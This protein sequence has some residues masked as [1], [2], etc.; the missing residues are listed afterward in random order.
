MPIPSASL[1]S[2]LL[3]RRDWHYRACLAITGSYRQ[4]DV[5][6]LE[7]FRAVVDHRSVTLAAA[8]LRVMQP[9]VSTQIACLDRG[10][11]R[12]KPTPEGMLFYAEADKML[13]GMNCLSEAVRQIR[14]AQAGFIIANH[15]SA[16][17]Y[18]EIIAS[19]VRD[20]EPSVLPQ[21]FLLMLVDK[22]GPL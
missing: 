3:A 9:P 2:P 22:L 14:T 11:G 4:M 20:R 8:A 1:S 19:C 6:L 16:T 12:L 21:S 18:H 17:I 10:D 5:R 15:P 7:A 13:T